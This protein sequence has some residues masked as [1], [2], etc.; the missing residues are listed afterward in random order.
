MDSNNV[1]E[2]LKKYCTE[3][4]DVV[5]SNRIKGINS[6]D[7]KIVVEMNGTTKNITIDE[8][9]SN[10]WLN[11]TVVEETIE[12]IETMP[13]PKEELEV[14]EEPIESL[15]EPTKQESNV[16]ILSTLKD[17]QDAIN[18]KDEISINKA[19]ETFAVDQN[20]NS[21]NMNKAIKVI[22]DNSTNN[23]INSVK[24]N[25]LLPTDLSSY[26]ITGRIVTPVIN[27]QDKVDVQSLIDISFNNILVYVEAAKL[28][29]IVFSDS[30]IAAAKNKYATGI[31]DKMNVQGLNKQEAPV[32]NTK[33]ESDD[34]TDEGTSTTSDIKPDTNIKKAGFA[35]IFIL[36]IIILIY[37]AIIVNLVTKLK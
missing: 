27:S 15:E 12:T 10:S 35:D 17:V 21:I 25:T 37:I 28:K 1:I 19:L 5:K 20:N 34:T 24:N 33:D 3:H 13:E 2:R 23:V 9:E 11:P 7:S 6:S 29:N 31:Q 4:P 16:R 14:M 26:D 22:T 36:S 30:Q 8:L 32:S 18:S